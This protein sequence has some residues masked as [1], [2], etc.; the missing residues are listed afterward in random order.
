[1]SFVG[2]DFTAHAAAV[3]AWS[4]GRLLAPAA[5]IDTSASISEPGQS[6]EDDSFCKL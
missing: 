1:M 5:M 3:D 4:A 6:R 2:G